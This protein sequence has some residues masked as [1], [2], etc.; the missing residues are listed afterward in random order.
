MIRKSLVLVLA[1]LA[2]TAAAPAFAK[3]SSS[4]KDSGGSTAPPTPDPAPSRDDAAVAF[5]MNLDNTKFKLSDEDAISNVRKCLGF[6]KDEAVSAGA[7]SKAVKLIDWFAHHKSSPV[8]LA[9]VGAL[10]EVGKG[11]GTAKLVMLLDGLMLQKDAPAA[12]VAAVLGA[13]RNAADPDPSV[14]RAVM[15]VLVQRDGP[16]AAKAADVL[17]NY[18]DA[19]VDVKRKLFE[20]M[21][22]AFETMAAV[23]P[24]NQPGVDKWKAM[25]FPAVAALGSLSKQSFADVPA[26]RKWFN[27]KGRDPTAWK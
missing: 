9:A 6:W 22:L 20:D 19:P 3:G 10:G 27:E 14:T 7:K 26:A 2:A 23:K 8:V 11:A 5:L 24:D 4:K 16:T 12:H 25:S 21:L 18:T 17:G 15:A 13:L 1:A